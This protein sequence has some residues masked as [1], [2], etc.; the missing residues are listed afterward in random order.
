VSER[1]FDWLRI[2]LLALAVVGLLVSGQIVKKSEGGTLPA[3]LKWACGGAL[4]C[5]RVLNSPY[6]K[7]IQIPPFPVP[8]ST[9]SVGMAY[10]LV[11][12]IWLLLV[13]QLPGKLHHAWAIPAL[14]GT[15]GLLASGWMVY[16]MARVL[17][18]WCGLCLAVHVADLVMVLGIW[19]LWLKGRPRT[20]Q[21]PSPLEMA[22]AAARDGSQAWKIPAM[23]LAAGLAVGLAQLRSAQ[24][25][26][27][28]G[29]IG[30]AQAEYDSVTNDDQYRKFLFDKARPIQIPINPDDPTSGPVLARHQLII[31]ADFQC[32]HC[33]DFATLVPKI[34]AELGEPM[35]V[36]FKYFPL[37]GKCNPG[38][39]LL[40]GLDLF[41]RGCDAAAAVDAARQ[42]GG[43]EIFW[44]AHEM[45][46]Q[47]HNHLQNLNYRLLAQAL[48]LDADAFDRLRKDPA[49]M[50]HIRKVAAQGA[51]AGV[52]TT[53]A[54]FLDG[55]RIEAPWKNTYDSQQ[56]K[57]MI[58]VSQTISYWRNLLAWSQSAASQPS[59]QAAP[60]SI[61]TRSVTR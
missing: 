33:A 10:F 12:G 37:S 45:V 50:D 42:M 5:D 31:F 6:A 60:R 57:H 55:R 19:I 54:I 35:H 48:G 22:P 59:A 3:S 26:E 9:A 58:D 24:T 39:P 44:K 61:T 51:A 21:E 15:G 29:M 47:G 20:R 11:M 13:G 49:V 56:R 34:Q 18:A 32:P 40:A 1:R 23:A 43:N 41:E 8:V 14:L 53:P 27:A 36:V 17:H 25:S 52:H 2:V 4:D 30:Q 38:R 28:V 7:I 16:V 46:F